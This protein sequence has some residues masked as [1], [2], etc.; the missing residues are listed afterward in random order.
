MEIATIEDVDQI[1]IDA[2]K[3]MRRMPDGDEMKSLVTTL[4]IELSGITALLK[5]IAKELIIAREKP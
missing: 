5:I 4:G 3:A 1:T 2:E